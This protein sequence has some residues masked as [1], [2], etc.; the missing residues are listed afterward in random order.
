MAAPKEDN[1]EH[2]PGV[3]GGDLPEK[4]RNA[5]EEGHDADIPSSDRAVKPEREPLNK[6]TPVDPEK[7]DKRD[8]SSN[9]SEAG[10]RDLEK[11]QQTTTDEA[12]EQ[13]DPNVVDW[14][15]PE[16][17]QNPYN[18][19]A[20]KKWRNIAMLSFLTLLT[21]L[22]SSMFAPGVP[23]VIK[24]FHTSNVSL[25]TFVVSVY[26]LGFAAGPLIIAPLSEMY[27]RVPIYNIC[28]VCF[29][30]FNVGCA[31]STNMGMLI[32]FRFLAG[33]FGIAPITNGGG[34]IADL[35]A[36][37][38]RGAAM[39]IWAIGPLL[40]PVIGPVCGSF[41]SQAAGWRW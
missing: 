12:E 32:G 11:A 36:P 10:D 28:N 23:D 30:A 35:M 40:G 22:A 3:L 33:C 29:V 17:P 9:S 41:L 26:I 2:I 20:A 37:E 15:G 34:T 39:S 16:D 18:W 38:Q 21:P 1:N 5:Y 6:E 4:E 24:E 14:D 7:G 25:A 27:G 19:S 8:V 31:L 13:Q